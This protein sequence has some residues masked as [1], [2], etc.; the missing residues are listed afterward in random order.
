MRR[1]VCGSFV[2][3][4]IIL[5]IAMAGVSVARPA[6]GYSVLA[7]EANIDAL[8][9]PAIKSM[10]LA[11]Y[12]K[13]TP[14]QL[15][16]ARAYAYGGCVIQ[17]LGYYPFGSRFFSNLLHYVRTGDFVVSLIRNARDVNEYAF[18]LGALGH[19]AS[20]NNGHPMAVNRAVPM[21]Y[22]KLKAEFG[23]IVTYVQ[24]P[25][26]HV[27]VEFSFDVVQVAAGAY[28]P[29]AY[30][31]YIGFRVAKPALERAFLDTYGLEMKDLFLSEDLAIG[32]YRHGVGTTIPEITKLAWKKKREQIEKVTPGV[33]RET[34]VF[35][36]SRR[37]YEKEFGSDYAKPHGFARV[38][39]LVYK[40]VPKIGPFRSLSFTVPTS[41]AE[42]L[43]LD[44]FTTTRERFRQSL[45]ALRNRRL[46]LP[47]TD[48]DTGR[49]T[50][51]GEYPLA[52]V[53][54]DEL[55]DKLADRK[56]ADVPASLSANLVAYYGNAD[57]LPGTIRDGQKRS[58]KVRQRL[59]SLKAACSCP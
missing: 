47:N 23:D 46:N 22:P 5:T 43:F 54:Y 11:R 57:P 44:S 29:E 49:P 12:P 28:A 10:L 17:D 7:H 19:Y 36:L 4:A 21:M 20:D 34:F 53:T 45:D 51:R 55:L 41:E 30:H 8:W 39:A 48:L 27:L 16:E 56:F 25:T 3:F 6:A 37:Q 32:T 2:R 14:E 33:Q 31:S 50:A 58:T 26:K 18:A 40:L 59:A 15:V 9:E 42:R 52:D 38:V 1:R 13:T 24:S 35:N